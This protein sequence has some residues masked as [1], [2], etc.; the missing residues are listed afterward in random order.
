MEPSI[1]AL[2]ELAPAATSQTAQA[3]LF[4]DVSWC[5]FGELSC[6]KS[7]RDLGHYTDLDQTMSL[8]SY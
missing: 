1:G 5:N 6:N 4:G 3:V 7:Q 8:A 2:L